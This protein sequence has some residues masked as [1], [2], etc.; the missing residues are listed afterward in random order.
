MFGHGTMRGPH[1]W[2]AGVPRRLACAAV[3]VNRLK[4]PVRPLHWLRWGLA[5]VIAVSCPPQGLLTMAIPFPHER[6]LTREVWH[7]QIG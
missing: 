1:G 2:R 4:F 5:R 3:D 7:A 6:V